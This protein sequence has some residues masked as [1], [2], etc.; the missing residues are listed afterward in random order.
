MKKIEKLT[1]DWNSYYRVYRN[2]DNYKVDMEML[3]DLKDK[4][5]EVVDVV[6]ELA[7]SEEKETNNE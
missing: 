3:N 6:N 7:S 1:R 4:L 5:N 2:V